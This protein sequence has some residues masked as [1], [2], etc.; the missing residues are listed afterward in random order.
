MW[1]MWS[2]FVLVLLVSIFMCCNL[3]STAKLIVSWLVLEDFKKIFTS[4]NGIKMAFSVCRSFGFMAEQRKTK[5]GH[6]WIMRF[7]FLRTCLVVPCLLVFVAF[8]FGILIPNYLQKYKCEQVFFF[9]FLKKIYIKT[10]CHEAYNE[11]TCIW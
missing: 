7:S 10:E 1:L 4:W 3:E 2:W 9:Y 11:F 5:R 8:C 6:R